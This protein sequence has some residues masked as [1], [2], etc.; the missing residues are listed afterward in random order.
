MSLV[1]TQTVAMG[2]QSPVQALT[3]FCQS[4]TGAYVLIDPMLGEPLPDMVQGVAQDSHALVRAREQ[5]WGRTIF[6]VS[7]ATG[8]PLHV[9]QYP[10][11]V[12]LEGPSDPWWQT[13]W[14]MAAEASLACLAEGVTGEGGGPLPIGGWLISAM[15]QQA[16][17]DA[18][19]DLFRL[20]ADAQ[21]RARYLRLADPRVMALVQRV[22]GTA[23][24]GCQRN[25][26]SDTRSVSTGN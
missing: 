19:G 21:T 11:L 8:T 15:G 5:T 14:E 26:K 9:S 23:R 3:G 7:L 10:Y 4:G 24:L 20:R 2:Q 18:L 17:V 1:L 6:T 16:L 12:E 22:V 25:P 13:T